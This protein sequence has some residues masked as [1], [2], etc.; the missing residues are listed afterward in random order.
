MQVLIVLASFPWLGSLDLAKPS[1]CDFCPP[2]TLQ[3][4]PHV[5]A[6]HF[7]GRPYHLLYHPSAWYGGWAVGTSNSAF[8]VPSTPS[9]HC[10]CPVPFLPFTHL[11]GFWTGSS[12]FSSL[13]ECW[14]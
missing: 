3:F 4:L 2:F 1:K 10:F 9:P 13:V 11:Q 14:G 8:G 6:S 5:R 12:S 7:P